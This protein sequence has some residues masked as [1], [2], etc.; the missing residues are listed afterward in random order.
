M[1]SNQ[2]GVQFYAG[3][4]LNGSAVGKSGHAYRQSDGLAL[5]PQL[6]PDTPN[7]PAFGT[8]RLDPGQTYENR[9]LYRFSTVRR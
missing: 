6:F 1:L 9:I 2:P 8:A 3:N 5:E 7:Q 4:F